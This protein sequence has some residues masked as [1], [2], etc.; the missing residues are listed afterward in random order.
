MARSSDESIAQRTIKGG[1]NSFQGWTSNLARWSADAIDCELYARG[2][3]CFLKIFHS[4]RFSER[5]GRCKNKGR[6]TA[7]Q[8][9]V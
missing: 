5:K 9:W 1:Q 2:A 3:I 8:T 7:G 4:E 6:T